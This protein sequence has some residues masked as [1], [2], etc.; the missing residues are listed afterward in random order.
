MGMSTPQSQT[1]HLIN[2]QYCICFWSLTLQG[3]PLIV[4]LMLENNGV[5]AVS[6]K[7]KGKTAR[8]STPTTKVLLSSSREEGLENIRRIEICKQKKQILV[9]WNS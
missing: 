1:I 9:Y 5:C 4:L 7:L 2:S 3:H 6:A 8:W